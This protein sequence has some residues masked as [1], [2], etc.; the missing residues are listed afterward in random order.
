[1]HKVTTSD[2]RRRLLRVSTADKKTISLYSEGIS[3]SA[4]FGQPI[5]D[6][7]DQAAVDRLKLG[8]H[9]LRVAARMSNTAGRD[10]RSVIGRYYY[11][12][13]HSVRAVSYFVYRGDDYQE[14]NKLPGAIP[15]DFPNKNLWANEL[16]DARF[17]RNEADYDLYRNGGAHFRSNAIALAPIANSLVSECRAYM[18]QKGCKF[19]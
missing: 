6:V 14:H 1:M 3:H 7:F 2:L 4:A 16:K 9:F 18:K 8:E 11:A 12:M 10:W 19:L 17:R 15:D 5:E 13:Y